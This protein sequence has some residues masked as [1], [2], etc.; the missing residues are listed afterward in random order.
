MEGSSTPE[1]IAVSYMMRNWKL[2]AMR[3]KQQETRKC[4][5]TTLDRM[6]YN[7]L[8]PVHGIIELI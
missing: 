4:A 6:E 3:G 5:L 7:L 1:M 8:L 2:A